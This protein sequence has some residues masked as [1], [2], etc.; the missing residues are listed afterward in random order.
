MSSLL[1]RSRTGWRTAALHLPAQNV[2]MMACPL[3]SSRERMPWSLV[4]P[5]PPSSSPSRSQH[6]WRPSSPRPPRCTSASAAMTRWHHREGLG[7]RGQAPD[8]DT[9]RAQRAGKGEGRSPHCGVRAQEGH[10]RE[11]V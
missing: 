7:H 8:R 3:L 9:R 2:R 5:L 1:L 10:R 4:Q 6:R 11:A